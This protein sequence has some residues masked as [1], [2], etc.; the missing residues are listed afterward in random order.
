MEVKTL[1]SLLISV[2]VL[3]AVGGIVL[4]GVNLS[5]GRRA[6]P[7]VLLFAIA[8][9][10][11]VVL[12]PL[13]AGLVLIQPNEVGVVFRQTSRGEAALL[14]PLPTGLNWVVPFVDQVIPFNVG[15]QNV[16]MAGTGEITDYYDQTIGESVG[17]TSVR[18][19]T[20]DGQVV[21]LDVTVIFR[22]DPTRVNYVYRNWRQG[23][24]ENFV[25]PLTRSEVRNAIVNYGAEEIYSG[26]RTF[27]EE[28]ISE[29]IAPQLA[30]QGLILTD[31][32]IRDVAFSPEFMDAIEQKQI[33]EQ[34][35]QRAVFLVQQQEQ[36]AERARVEAEGLADASVIRAEGEAEA[37]LL[38]AGAEAEA[39]RLIN[40]Q[41][42]QNPALIQWR[43]VDELGE[44]VRIIVV[45]SNSPFLF[46]LQ[47]LMT[48]AGI[49][50]EG[51]P[52]STVTEGG[53]PP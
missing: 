18:A 20:S 11:I 45:P 16:T 36:E 13:N 37:T 33:A 43:Y 50:S 26:G 15:Q 49:P 7:G 31:I 34:E 24:R 47:A 30:A 10:G 3:A 22:I 19:I 27:L 41:L 46:D 9:I 48:E 5:R 4:A 39:L 40:E 51:G 6:R 53:S 14:E 17:G 28:Q 52:E 8:L 23:F 1:L 44:N 2:L 12:A 38:Q 42:S 35:A 21:F 25:V 32:L 29:A